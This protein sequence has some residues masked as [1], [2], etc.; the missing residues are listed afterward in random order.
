MNIKKFTILNARDAQSEATQVVDI[1][2]NVDHIISLKPIKIVGRDNII[3]GHWIRL[4]NGKKYRAI[5]I[6]SDLSDLLYDGQVPANIPLN[7]LD[8]NVEV[9][10]LPQ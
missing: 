6:P 7:D 1:L 5:Q 8:A 4:T 3:Q 9:G 10:N 2:I